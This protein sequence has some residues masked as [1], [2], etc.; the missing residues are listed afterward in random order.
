M[1][2]CH[3]SLYEN[4]YMQWGISSLSSTFQT[5]TAEIWI[6]LCKTLPSIVKRTLSR[7]GH[8]L[9]MLFAEECCNSTLPM[10]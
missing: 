3:A 1:C 2:I 9:S 5:A 7:M 8:L 4:E 10:K 6:S